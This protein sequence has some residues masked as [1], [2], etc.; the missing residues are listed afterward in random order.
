[1]FPTQLL[2]VCIVNVCSLGVSSSEQVQ[3]Y[4]KL[5]SGHSLLLSPSAFSFP[6][7]CKAAP[8]LKPINP[9]LYII[10]VF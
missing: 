1:M 6:L 2:H 8:V 10:R 4:R 5:L 9:F 3:V 7:L